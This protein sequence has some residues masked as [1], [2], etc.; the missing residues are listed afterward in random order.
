MA[1]H[2]RRPQLE[3]FKYICPCLVTRI[4]DKIIKVAN[5][6]PGCVTNIKYLGITEIRNA[7]Q[8]CVLPFSS[9]LSSCLLSKNVKKKMYKIIILY[10]QVGT[11]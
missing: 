9:E 11:L 8:E 2:A 3:C 7:F 10:A 6:S 4:Q 5:K 1:S